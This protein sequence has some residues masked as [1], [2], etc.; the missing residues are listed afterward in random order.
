MLT[1]KGKTL[2]D[3]FVINKNSIRSI[4]KNTQISY[5]SDINDYIPDSS[6]TFQDILNNAGV[7]CVEDTDPLVFAVKFKVFKNFLNKKVTSFFACS[8]II[9]VIVENV[10]SNS[11]IDRLKLG[12]LSS[13][14]PKVIQDL[15][16]ENIYEQLIVYEYIYMS[17]Y[18]TLHKKLDIL[19]ENNYDILLS[20]LEDCSL[21]ISTTSADSE[22]IDL[23]KK[24]M[25]KLR[26]KYYVS[27]CP[28]K[29][30]M[31]NRFIEH[32]ENWLS[33]DVADLD[34]VDDRSIKIS[35][36]IDNPQIH[37]MVSADIIDHLDIR[38]DMTQCLL[39]EE[40]CH[41]NTHY[42]K[43]PETVNIILKV[44]LP[45]LKIGSIS[46]VRDDEET[47]RL[48]KSLDLIIRMMEND[49]KLVSLISKR[50][51]E[52]I[53]IMWLKMS[54]PTYHCFRYCR[55][56]PYHH[57]DSKIDHLHIHNQREIIR[58]IILSTTI[59]NLIS[60]ICITFEELGYIL[61]T[62]NLEMFEL[63]CKFTE[64]KNI[65]QTF[66]RYLPPKILGCIIDRS[67]RVNS[68]PFEKPRLCG[69]PK[70]MINMY[71]LI[72]RSKEQIQYSL[73]MLHKFFENEPIIELVSINDRYEY[74]ECLY[75]V[76]Y[77]DYLTMLI[78]KPDYVMNIATV[79]SSVRNIKTNLSNYYLDIVILKTVLDNISPDS[80]ISNNHI[81]E[82]L[83]TPQS[84]HS[85]NYIKT[86]LNRLINNMAEDDMM[87]LSG[88][89]F[90]EIS[91]ELSQYG[92]KNLEYLSEL[93][94]IQDKIQS[95]ISHSNLPVKSKVN[96]K[97]KNLI[98]DNND[99]NNDNNDNNNDNDNDN[100]NDDDD[101][102]NDD[103][104]DNNDNDDNDDDDYEVIGSDIESNYDSN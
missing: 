98:Y 56:Y 12:I 100:D 20:L 97:V 70:F 71:D 40:F 72:G 21:E 104:D 83:K 48:Y 42:Q 67:M 103:D 82:Q 10:P 85:Q 51:Q 14:I 88:P 50:T 52:K 84:I 58:K 87:M 92:V 35:N 79:L 101:D 43:K 64:F 18:H 27:G 36:M 33:Y 2:S 26:H 3:T 45:L 9:D 55:E 6:I 93:K 32:H 17:E 75:I 38:S 61:A 60:N 29:L 28:L 59:K 77:W 96:V 22:S 99:Y 78:K 23:S 62:D 90:T 15:G 24:E 69:S 74:V 11:V 94:T 89:D 25:I 8:G 46:N 63:M 86:S 53:I 73:N 95:N 81:D 65:H 41:L 68:D 91:E 16:L 49:N 54:S 57:Y 80:M 66:Y 30:L 1:I 76:M 102:N 31:F 4:L 7:L 5:I 19:V 47:I 39:I 37:S 44:L 13:A 34:E